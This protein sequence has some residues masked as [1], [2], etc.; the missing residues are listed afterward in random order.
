M[1]PF[2][3]NGYPK[4]LRIILVEVFQHL[5]IQGHLIA[6][7]GAPVRRVKGEDPVL[8]RKFTQPDLLIGGTV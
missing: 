1:A 8:A 7:Y 6:A 4:D 3:V 2:A 5:V